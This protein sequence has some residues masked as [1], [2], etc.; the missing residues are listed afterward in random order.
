LAVA[1]GSLF[2]RAHPKKEANTVLRLIVGLSVVTF[3]VPGA[4][5][6]EPDRADR[7][8]LVKGAHDIICIHAA[9]A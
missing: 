5:A 1:A 7:A 4:G 6:A 3:L 8:A 9:W 2:S